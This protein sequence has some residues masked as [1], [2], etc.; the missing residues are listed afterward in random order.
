MSDEFKQSKAA[1][2]KYRLVVMNDETFEEMGSYRLTL[3]NVYMVLC[4]VLVVVILFVV[5]IIAFTPFKRLIPGYGDVNMRSHIVELSLRTD[6]LEQ[7]LYDRNFYIENIRRVLVGD[8]ETEN[9]DVSEPIYM[10]T[11][12]NIAPIPE[13]SLLR[14][15]V[16]RDELIYVPEGFGDPDKALRIETDYLI[17]PLKGVITDSFNIPE[18][19]F[20][21]DLA[22]PSQ[23]PVKNILDGQVIF[24]G[25]TMETGYTIGIQH[26]GN[27]ISFYKH[28]S[29]LLKK[30]G[31][32][33]K[34][35]EAIA[36][37]GNSGHLSDGPHLH[38]E[39]WY[40][41]QPVNPTS[42]INF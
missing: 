35:G 36:I 6:S 34:A 11:I 17:P 29:V 1:A 16:A 2:N 15:Q 40:R 13:D 42:Y 4:T 9:V 18:E 39:L 37:I 30:V 24:S 41:G 27:L 3:F 26:E 23:S 19:H 12:F 8:L 31:K 7:V 21:V 25:W 32:F 22:A 5:S 14:E 38:F 20:G 28:N 33:V 10:D